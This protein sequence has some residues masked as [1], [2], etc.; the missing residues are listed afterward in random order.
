MQGNGGKIEAN[1]EYSL[2]RSNALEISTD[3]FQKAGFTKELFVEYISSIIQRVSLSHYSGHENDKVLIIL[4]R[5]YNQGWERSGGNAYAEEILVATMKL[6]PTCVEEQLN[7]T[8][9]GREDPV[10]YTHLD[11]YKRQQYNCDDQH[12]YVC[13]SGTGKAGCKRM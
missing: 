9:G 6:L 1:E 2:F 5:A 7:A 10:S 8:T 13:E 12:E 11:V 4:P 3:I